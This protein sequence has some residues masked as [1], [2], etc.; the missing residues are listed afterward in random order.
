M[1]SRIYL[2]DESK[3]IRIGKEP[4]VLVPL[5]VWQ[6]MEDFLED[7]EALSSKN[8]LRRVRKARTDAARRKL[9]YPFR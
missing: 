7:R 3:T 1:A 4:M 2:L 5:K 8:Y 6:K 9:I